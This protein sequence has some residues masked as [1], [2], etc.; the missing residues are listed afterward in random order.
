MP[1]A[2][3]IVL[4]PLADAGQGRALGTIHDDAPAILMHSGVLDDLVA[5]S[6]SDLRREIGAFLL[7]VRY[8]SPRPAIE[9]RHFLPALDAR[10]AAASLTFTHDT[11]SA[12]HREAAEKY[13]TEIVLGW[14]HTH[15]GFGVFLSPQDLFIQRHFFS[16]PW[17]IALVVDPRRCEFGFF[18][19]RDGNIVDCGFICLPQR[20][21]SQQIG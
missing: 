4:P 17:Q 13:P 5:Y 15:P 21:E 18:Q 8:E 11:W 16:T 3:S 2:R 9:I 14:H 10:S 1:S 20:S 12:L 19:W 7:G 6:A